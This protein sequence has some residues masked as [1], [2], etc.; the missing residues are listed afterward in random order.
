[1]Y[2]L[3]C[4]LLLLVNLYLLLQKL[5]I[6]LMWIKN[7]IEISNEISHIGHHSLVHMLFLREVGSSYANSISLSLVRN[8]YFVRA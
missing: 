7:K 4:I 8:Y 2:R 5:L 1:M 3:S 6:K